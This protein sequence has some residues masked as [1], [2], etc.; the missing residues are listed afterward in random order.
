MQCFVKKICHKWVQAALLQVHHWCHWSYCDVLDC[1]AVRC[2]QFWWSQFLVRFVSGLLYSN[3]V[4]IIS[5]SS[6]RNS[7]WSVFR[8]T[9]FRLFSRRNSIGFRSILILEKKEMY[10]TVFEWFL[11]QF[12]DF[13]NLCQDCLKIWCLRLENAILWEMQNMI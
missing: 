10:K 3:V 12:I 7:T 11:W 1:T 4:G 6:S 9:F 13:L 8:G 5:V 2:W